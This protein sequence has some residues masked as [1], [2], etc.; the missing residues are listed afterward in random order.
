[1]LKYRN[2]AIVFQEVP[3]EIS[4]GIN[5]SG[6]QHRCPGCHSQ[7]LWEDAGCNLLDDLDFLIERHIPYISCICFMGGD[8]DQTEL[9]KACEKVKQRGL[10]TCLYT[11]I[12]DVRKL[13]M[14]LCYRLDYL[15]LGHY[16]AEKGPI[17]MPT[18]NQRF[19]SLYHT[20]SGIRYRD[21]T[22]SFWEKDL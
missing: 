19:Y 17:N 14:D 16:D 21:L 9:I 10:K 13:D 11:G 12:D 1:M 18:T 3:N 2:Y 4:L 20:R 22:S 8:H 7:Y 6:C 15:K 5:I